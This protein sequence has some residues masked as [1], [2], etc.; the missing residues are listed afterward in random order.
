[1]SRQLQLVR[2]CFGDRS[3]QF[4]ARNVHIGLE[5]RHPFRCPVVHRA[6]RVLGAGQLA[7]LR[8]PG[9]RTLQIRSRRIDRR[10]R[11]KVRIDPT[12]YF[13]I[14]IRLH[15]SRRPHRRYA[16]G[17]VK[18][19]TRIRSFGHHQSRLLQA[20][21]MHLHRI[22]VRVVKV[23]VHPNQARNHRVPGALDRLRLLRHSHAPCRSDR[24]DPPVA[25]HDRLILARRRARS[26]DHT[27]MLQRK[28]RRVQ[29]DKRRHVRP[30][31]ILGRRHS[32]KRK[33]PH[34]QRQQT[35]R[36]SSLGW[37]SDR[38]AVSVAHPPSPRREMTSRMA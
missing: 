29:I 21:V 33:Q 7:H 34:T 3:P 1:M 16:S 25:H 6:L 26:I 4:L 5:R 28:H 15:A 36:T 2:V 35:H 11:H 14:S 13:Q 23:I 12:L 38:G 24:F 18:P 20:P 32:G 17:K 10:S 37:S 27:D 31:R 22:R 8:E 30:R 9:R 19:G